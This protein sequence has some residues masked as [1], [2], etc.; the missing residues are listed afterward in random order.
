[1]NFFYY[2]KILFRGNSYLVLGVFLILLFSSI[3]EMVS[4][5]MLA[6]IIDSII[7]SSI[8]SS[9][10]KFFNIFFSKY[11]FKFSINLLFII[12]FVIIL[13]KSLFDVWANKFLLKLKYFFIKKI[14]SKTYDSIFN[15]NWQ[16]FVNESYGKLI[17]TFTKEVDRVG[18]SLSSV[19]RLLSNL[20]KI[21]IFLLVPFI[22]SWKVS[23]ICFGLGFLLSVPLFFLGKYNRGLG[24]KETTTGNSY[25]S[26]LQENISLAKII[27]SY[28]FQKKSLN[29]LILKFENHVKAAINAGIFNLLISN[30]YL[31]IGILGV[32]MIYYVGQY[33][34]LTLSDTAIILL[35]YYKIIPLLREVIN[36]KNAID[37]TY[38][39][40]NQ[41]IQLQKKALLLKNHFGTNKFLEFKTYLKFENVDYSYG[42]K[43]FIQ[44]L[45][46]TINKGDLVA[47]VGKSGSGKT[48]I[49]DLIM[50]LN[51]PTKGKITIDDEPLENY[52]INSF[53]SKIGYIPQTSLLFNISIYENILWGSEMA[54]Q[55]EVEKMSK[56]VYA[57]DFISS[58]E[59]GYSTKAGERGT[60]L[61][62]GQL[63]RISLARALIKN[64]E[65]L[66]LDEAT[67]S[68]DSESELKIQK[69]LDEYSSIKT[70]IVIAHRLSTIQ[71][72][73]KIFVISNGSIIE[74]GDFNSLINANKNF[75]KM[76]D[77]QVFVI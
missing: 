33:Y 60:R 16:F 20:I 37:I 30:L 3:I 4:L 62:G 47:F 8:E 63:Q 59:D 25:V 22:L 51:V 2:L 12:Y 10:T 17:N 71:K 73:N 38:P 6:P 39:S 48:T 53:R 18:D 19:G 31:P 29:L 34:V 1:M 74:Q 64:P 65:I 75:K 50:G 21:I 26:S 36:S 58:F 46:F 67:S 24:E 43:K 61:S 57:H 52:E 66:I 54:T 23:L 40:Y 42:D 27:I 5:L 70:I 45:S 55:Q 13:I 49:I 72:A 15:S 69:T 35:V 56:K 11:N 14:V 68:L 28:G 9:I 76:V 7:N 32:V 41:I 44:N 77:Q